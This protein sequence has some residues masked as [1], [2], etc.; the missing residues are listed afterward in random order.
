MTP[1]RG[2]RTDPG[3]DDGRLESLLDDLAARDPQVRDERALGAVG[4]A[5]ATGVLTDAQRARVADRMLRQL[6]HPEVQART[7]AP[8]VL[9]VLTAH[10]DWDDGWFERVREWY[11]SER[12]LRGHDAARGWLHAV[13]HGADFFGTAAHTRRCAAADALEVLAERVLLPCD[14]VWRD[15]EEA[16]VA[17]AMA[18]A[19]VRDPAATEWLDRVDQR[20]AGLGAPRP[21]WAA[22]TVNTLQALALGLEQQVLVDGGPVQL[23]DLS[24]ARARVVQVIGQAQPWFWRVR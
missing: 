4:A 9:A 22:N 11:L 15:Q 5:I 7:F 1:D 12:D 3:M 8:L 18:L 19:L 16:R 17:Y 24:G 14:A 23:P 2:H 10:G 6:R 13:A 20:L 21:A